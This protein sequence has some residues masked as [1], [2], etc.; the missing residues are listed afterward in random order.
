MNYALKSNSK[1]QVSVSTADLPV[2]EYVATVVYKGNS[3][4]NPS[5]TTAKVVV[6]DKLTSCISGVYNAETKEV[7]GTLTNSAGT[8][9]SANVVVSING[10]DYA[11]KSDSKGK[12]KVS[13]ANLAPGKYV[14]KLIYKGNSK[15]NPASTT[16]N[17][18]VS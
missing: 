18:V 11:M 3:K 16:V 17:V 1:G 4:Y 10:V 12:F 6:N 8:P 14:A 15:Y 7:V 9:L 13:T 2:G 5:S